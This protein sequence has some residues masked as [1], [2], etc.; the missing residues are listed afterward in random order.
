MPRAIGLPLGLMRIPGATHRAPILFQHGLEHLQ[1]RGHDQLLE[2]R[3]GIHEDL[4]QRQV[5]RRRGCRLAT[6]SDCARLLLHGGSF[7]GEAFTSV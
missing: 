6:T 3:L 4:D 5:T 2:L 1:A 7:A